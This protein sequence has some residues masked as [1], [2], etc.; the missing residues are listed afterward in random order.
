[1]VCGKADRGFGIRH[2]KTATQRPVVLAST[3]CPQIREV[4]IR[5]AVRRRASAFARAR[6]SGHGDCA[7]STRAD[8]PVRVRRHS[9]VDVRPGVRCSDR[10]GIAIEQRDQR[11]GTWACDDGLGLRLA[12]PHGRGRTGNGRS[13]RSPVSSGRSASETRNS[14]RK[15]RSTSGES[16]VGAHAVVAP[17]HSLADPD[18]AATAGCFACPAVEGFC[19]TAEPAGGQRSSCRAANGSKNRT[20]APVSQA[21][22]I[23]IPNRRA[24]RRPGGGDRRRPP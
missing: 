14:G 15:P 13:A 24:R 8:P 6:R 20:T 4:G 21:V 5:T 2:H 11:L 18:V 22:R 1:M 12:N 17:S 3:T 7:E 16:L 10:R 23:P 19:A 9:A